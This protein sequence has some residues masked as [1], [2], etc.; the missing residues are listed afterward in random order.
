MEEFSS[1]LLENAVT[2]LNRLPGI[3]KKTALRLALFLL[4][5]E[6]SMV[7][8]FG[9]TLIDFR[10]NIQYCK[11][12]HNICEADFCEIC[13]SSRRDNSLLCVV[14]DIRD[15][16]AIENTG[17]YN[18]L[19]HVLNGLINPLAGISPS[20]LTISHLIERVKDEDIHEVIMA[21]PATP[22]GDTTAFYISRQLRQQD[23]RISTIARG[24]AIGEDLEYTD[25]I[26]LGRS[27]TNRV[28]F[29]TDK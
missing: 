22:E 26:T 7:E 18:G 12:C 9:N 6:K 21:V 20:Q 11:R 23:V 13:N 25:E 5:Q 2:E 10:N 28:E 17:M 19:Y 15:V 16:M 29:H 24:I 4:S 8:K 27:L 3:G 14:S 1:K